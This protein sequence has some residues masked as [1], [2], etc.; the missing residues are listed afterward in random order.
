VGRL[1]LPSSPRTQG[2]DRRVSALDSLARPG[3]SRAGTA[4]AM[5]IEG[6]E[7]PASSVQ[8]LTVIA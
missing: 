3:I 1:P 8:S 2:K 5:S 7:A 4:G 6:T